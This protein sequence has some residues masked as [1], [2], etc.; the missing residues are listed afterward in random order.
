M[1]ALRLNLFRIHD[2]SKDRMIG[3]LVSVEDI[4]AY[5]AECSGAGA[6]G[7]CKTGIDGGE[8][9]TKT[10]RIN[11]MMCEHCEATVKKALEAL[12]FVSEARPSHTDGTAVLVLDGEFEEEAVRKAV[13]EKDYRYVG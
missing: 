10:L 1:N 12:P 7:A 3:R 9:M 5:A 11:G 13:E 2:A 4:T 8:V 6:C